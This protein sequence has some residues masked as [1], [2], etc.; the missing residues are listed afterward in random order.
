MK[1]L[2]TTKELAEY[3]NVHPLSINRKVLNGEIPCIKLSKR[4]LRFD[5]DEVMKALKGE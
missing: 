1:K 2:L 3:L 4:N 5:L